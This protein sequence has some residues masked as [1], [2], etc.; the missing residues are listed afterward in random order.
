M[1]AKRKIAMANPYAKGW[2]SPAKLAI[3]K[4]CSLLSNKTPPLPVTPLRR[5]STIGLGDNSFRILALRR[6]SGAF[7]GLKGCCMMRF[8]PVA[9]AVSQPPTPVPQSSLKVT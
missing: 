3:L 2:L 7:A 1:V 9:G 8:P 4:K 6:A 5:F